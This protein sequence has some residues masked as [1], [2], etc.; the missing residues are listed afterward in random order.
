MAADDTSQ[1]I[2]L[3]FIIDNVTETIL[4]YCHLDQLP[5]GLELTSYRM[6]IDLYRNEA[7]GEADAPIGSVSSITEGDTQTS[8]NKSVTENYAESLLKNYQA[9]LNRYRKLVWQ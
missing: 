5:S 3:Q 9:Q 4:N 1:D 6:A 2:N 7:I 8:F